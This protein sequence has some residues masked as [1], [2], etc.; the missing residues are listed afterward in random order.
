[1]R[2]T[3]DSDFIALSVPFAERWI[4]F[5]EQQ[6]KLQ[7]NMGLV[8]AVAMLTGNVVG[9]SVFIIPGQLASTIG[10]AVWLSYI[11]GAILISFTCFIFAQVGSILPVAGSIYR[12]CS[13]TVNGFWGFIYILVFTLSSIFLFPIMSKTAANYIAAIFPGTN[14]VLVALVIIV[15]TG[16]INL[17][18]SNFSAIVQAVL[19]VL[20][21]AVVLIFSG[22]GIVNANWENFSPMFPSGI[23]PIIIGAISTYYAFAG[24]NN[25]IELSGEIKNPRKNIMRM[26]FLS[27]AIIIVMYLGM[28][29]GLVGLAHPSELGVDAPAVFA[30]S[31]IFP[32]WFSLFISLAAFAASWT[33]LNGVM[34]AMSRQFYALGRSGVFPAVVSKLSKRGTPVIAVSVVTIIGIIINLFSA[35]VMRFV[36][37]S[38]LYLLATALVV[39]VSSLKIKEKLKQQY[40]QAEY[41]LKGAWYY[42]WPILTIASSIVFMVLAIRED[43]KMSLIS[44]V[45]VPVGLLL[46][47]WRKKRYESHGVSL[48]ESIQKSMYEDASS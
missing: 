8:K 18:G 23:T 27:F 1:M 46:Y 19:T 16:V 31:R 9:A 42:I 44:I 25:V 7:R 3:Q 41:K 40:D 45:L 2:R 38:S 32:S 28:C 26:V 39:A 14:V 10:S 20:L 11:I 22:G 37:V 12:L 5:M 6:N 29:V 43:L 33:T 47:L 21:V 15:I 48:D 17:F 24:F 34:A 30:G 4:I 13:V 36:N 35:T